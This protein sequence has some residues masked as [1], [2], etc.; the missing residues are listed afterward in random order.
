M[1]A[2]YGKKTVREYI[3]RPE[4]ELFDISADPNEG[5]N[6]A[7]DE[8]YAEVLE[9]Y[10]AKLKAFQSTTQDPWIMKWKYE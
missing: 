10:K 2:P 1:N 7:I 3:K 5:V 9:E 4:F 6:L 8:K